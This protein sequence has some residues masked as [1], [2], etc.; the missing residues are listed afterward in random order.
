MDSALGT[1]Y[2]ERSP[3]VKRKMS[4]VASPAFSVILSSSGMSSSLQLLLTTYN[5][6]D[7]LEFGG[8]R[9]IKI[10]TWDVTRKQVDPASLMSAG[11]LG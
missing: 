8:G 1:I 2:Y 7:L 4:R 9:R 6:I 3:A 10:G 5:R 11:E